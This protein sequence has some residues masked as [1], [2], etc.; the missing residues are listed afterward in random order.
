MIHSYSFCPCAKCQDKCEFLISIFIEMYHGNLPILP[1]GLT[2]LLK[3]LYIANSKNVVTVERTRI[4]PRPRGTMGLSI[5]FWIHT[6]LVLLITV[7]IHL[8]TKA[9]VEMC[10]NMLI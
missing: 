5:V 2:S 4:I 3:K 10:D 1:L 7:F 6:S 9:L 8:L